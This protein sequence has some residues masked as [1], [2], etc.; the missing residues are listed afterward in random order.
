MADR[1]IVLLCIR[2]SDWLCAL[3]PSELM[4]DSPRDASREERASPRDA[5]REERGGSSGSWFG[6]YAWS[7]SVC[8]AS[9]TASPHL[10][11]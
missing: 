5:S 1:A 2:F 6:A 4:T 3:A 10:T 11:S 8:V 7:W 9:D